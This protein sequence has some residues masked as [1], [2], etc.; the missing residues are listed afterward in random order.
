[1]WDKSDGSFESIVQ[2]GHFAYICLYWRFGLLD[3]LDIVKFSHMLK[4]RL[5]LQGL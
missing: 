5:K 1:L 4:L 2:C 3:V